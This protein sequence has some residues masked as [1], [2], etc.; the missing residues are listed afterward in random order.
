MSVGS[1]SLDSAS[2]AYA[3]VQLYAT[4]EHHRKQLNPC[5][6]HPH[7]AETGL[8]IRLTDGCNLETDSEED[9]LEAE[10]DPAMTLS[11]TARKRLQ[12]GRAHV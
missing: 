3:G 9:V 8:P 1:F 2:D 7:F 4:L 11:V 12:I 10:D 5:P 6:P